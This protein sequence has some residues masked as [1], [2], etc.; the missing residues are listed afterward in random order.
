M[1][2][3]YQVAMISGAIGMGAL[4]TA[5]TATMSGAGRSSMTMDVAKFNADNELVRPTDY[6]TWVYCGHPSHTERHEQRGGTVPGVS[7]RLHR[8]R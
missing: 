3:A 7:Q 5:C 4:I 2:K 6:R 8:S 1:K